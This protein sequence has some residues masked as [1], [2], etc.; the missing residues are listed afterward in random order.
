MLPYKYVFARSYW[1]MCGPGNCGPTDADNQGGSPLIYIPIYIP[2]PSSFFFGGGGFH[3]SPSFSCISPS[4]SPP[5]KSLSLISE[6]Q[7][8]LLL[9]LINCDSAHILGCRMCRTEITPIRQ[10]SSENRIAGPKQSNVANSHQSVQSSCTFQP[11]S[12]EVRQVEQAI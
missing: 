8:L 6:R 1:C 12:G 4:Q 11:N 7:R 9:R 10:H 2:I 5:Y 3:F